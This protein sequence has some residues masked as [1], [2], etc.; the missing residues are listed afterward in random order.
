MDGTMNADSLSWFDF[1][2]PKLRR[3]NA[4]HGLQWLQTLLHEYHDYLRTFQRQSNNILG[5]VF[6][7]LQSFKICLARGG[8]GDVI[9]KENK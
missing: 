1:L 6:L 4:L 2:H 3:T 9:K 5:L 8:G 7:G